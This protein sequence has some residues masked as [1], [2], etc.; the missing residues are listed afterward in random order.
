LDTKFYMNENVKKEFDKE[1][2]GIPYPQMDVKI[3]K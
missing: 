3:K 2:I 1:D